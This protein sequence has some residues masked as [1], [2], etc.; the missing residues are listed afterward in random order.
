MRTPPIRSGSEVVGAATTAQ[1]LAP[2][3]RRGQAASLFSLVSDRGKGRGEGIP[4]TPLE[5]GACGAAIM[6]GNQDGSQEA[7]VD[8]QNGF[9]C[10]SL[11][12]DH[13][14]GL[15]RAMYAD[16]AALAALAAAAP[17][18]AAARFGYR[19][20]VEEHKQVYGKPPLGVS[21]QGGTSA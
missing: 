4:L 14:A 1:D 18:V 16:P 19:R 10:P 8:G 15:L 20:F 6:V 9:V 13:Q 7:V 21:M 11:D 5:A 2:P 3:E 17:K 12:L